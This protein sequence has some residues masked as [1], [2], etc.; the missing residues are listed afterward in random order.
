MELYGRQILLNLKSEFFDIVNLGEDM[1]Q[2]REVISKMI[3]TIK[4]LIG[5]RDVTLFRVN[6]SKQLIIQDSSNTKIKKNAHITFSMND[7]SKEILL[8]KMIYREPL[9]I[10]GLGQYDLS[11][12]VEND[13]G[14]KGI[15]CLNDGEGTF[16]SYPDHILVELGEVCGSLIGKTQLLVEIITEE[17]RYKQLFRV[18][19][20]FHSSMNK[21]SVLEE[22]IHT[23]QEVFPTFIYNLYLSQDHKEFNSLPIKSLDYASN[24]NA[25]MQSYVT[26]TVTFEDILNDRK[27]ILYA[28]LKGKQGVYGVLQVIAPNTLVFP[29]KEVEFITLLANTAGGAI[30]NAQLFEQSKQLIT[31]LQLINETSQHL[32]SNLSLSDTMEYMTKK[33]I[34]SLAAEEAGF[35][36]LSP[37]LS[38]SIVQKGSTEYFFSEDASNIINYFKERIVRENEAIF[39]GDLE[40]QQDNNMKVEFKSVMAAPMIHSGVL[41]GFALAIHHQPYYFSFDTFKLFL[42]LIHHSTLAFINTVLREELEKMVITDHLTRLYSRNYLDEKIHASMQEDGGGTFI[43]IDI[44]NFKSVN[45]TYGHQIGDEVIIQV[46]DIIKSSIR[47][48]DIGAR[49]G[50]E[51]MAIYLPRVPLETGIQI[52]ERLV[53]KVRETSNPTV[54]ISCGVSHWEKEDSDSYVSLFKRADKALYT[55]KGTG[56]NKVVIETTYLDETT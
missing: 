25:L 18:T 15:L 41:K 14:F 48:S 33:V 44:D 19:E 55:A 39:I 31:D 30:E 34:K 45:D 42:S 36:M 32:N 6:E 2:N 8:S 17:K 56:K 47:G 52:A 29:K 21:E 27:S 10:D 16:Q 37:D 35:I 11:I 40:V 5:A 53:N 51:E 23:L 54:T 43:I 28:P 13:R 26:G 22:I 7:D 46:A 4:L 38:Q 9:V 3:F 49:W 50:G 1:I 12:L 20:K 24:E